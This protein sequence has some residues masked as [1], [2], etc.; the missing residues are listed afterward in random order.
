MRFFIVAPILAVGCSTSADPSGLD[1]G[2]STGD[3]HHGA[4]E[5]ASSEPSSSAQDPKPSLPHDGAVDAS[6]PVALD[7]GAEAGSDAAPP[8]G[9]NELLWIDAD[10]TFQT[11]PYPPVPASFP[12]SSWYSPVDYYGG[13]IEVRLEVSKKADATPAWIEL[14]MWQGMLGAPTH[15]CLHC[16]PEF[17]STGTY[18]CEM[19]PSQGLNAASVDFHD[20]FVAMQHR[21]KDGAGGVR[22]RDLTA[23][24]TSLPI[25]THYTVVLVPKG[26]TFSGWAAYAH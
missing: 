18:T 11:N 1:P 7:A 13:K 8:R 4:P 23:Y 9:K 5:G 22:G 3:S 10:V 26:A 6:T 25:V 15:T 14:C 16:L 2:A 24:P 19:S 21:A 12:P 20:P 17:T